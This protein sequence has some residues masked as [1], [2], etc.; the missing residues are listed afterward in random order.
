MDRDLPHRRALAIP[1]TAYPHQANERFCSFP[2]MSTNNTTFQM[3]ISELSGTHFVD[4]SFYDQLK[5]E[6]FRIC[7]R[8]G[9]PVPVLPAC[10]NSDR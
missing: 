2:G 6:V 3:G 4:L 5:L 10:V 9:K 8:R 1:T 7:G